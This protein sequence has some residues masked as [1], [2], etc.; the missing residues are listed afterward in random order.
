[1]RCKGKGVYIRERENP[2]N[3]MIIL[4]YKPSTENKAVFYFR[5]FTYTLLLVK[6]GTTDA[7]NLTSNAVD[8]FNLPV[9]ETGRETTRR[10]DDIKGFN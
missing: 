3:L 5:T 4:R 7:F 8:A 2:T 6:A 9:N 1:M 10:V